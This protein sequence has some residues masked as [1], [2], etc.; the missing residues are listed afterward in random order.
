ML[1]AACTALPPQVRGCWVLLVGDYHYSDIKLV[2][3]GDQAAARYYPTLG[4]MPTPLYQVRPLT[5][6]CSMWSK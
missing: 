2:R 1:L 3:G 4:H 6:S 5:E